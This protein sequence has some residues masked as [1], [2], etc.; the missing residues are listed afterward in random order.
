VGGGALGIGVALRRER[1]GRL[2]DERRPRV[3]VTAAAEADRERAGTG[4]PSKR[5]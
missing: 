5:G 3:R 1:V 4:T 2:G